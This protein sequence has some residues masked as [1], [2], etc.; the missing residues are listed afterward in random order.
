MVAAEWRVDVECVVLFG[1]D[2]YVLQVVVGE[3]ARGIGG[4]WPG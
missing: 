3:R 1:L 4:W 2:C